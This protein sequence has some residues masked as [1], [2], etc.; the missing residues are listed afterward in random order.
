NWIFL[1]E[2][3]DRTSVS[4]ATLCYYMAPT[5]VIVLSALLLREKM[6]AKKAL[7]ALLALVGMALV[8]GV[9]ETG[10]PPASE[11]RGIL[12]GLAAALLY[13]AVVLLNKSLP[14]V[15][16]YAKTTLQLGLAAL[17]LVPYL[18]AVNAFS[19]M[20]WDARTLGLLL[21]VGVLHTALCYALYFASM[22][23]LKTQTVALFSYIDPVAALLLSALLLHETLTP[24]GIFGALLILGSAVV[25]EL[26]E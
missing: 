7:C 13:A 23:G 2:A 14:A 21:V 17:V 5:F 22:D 24:L 18:L 26:G 3:Y 25:G 6:T 1:F 4:V 19:A 12:F 11:L 20:L 10:L 9:A 15:D 8:S 16:P